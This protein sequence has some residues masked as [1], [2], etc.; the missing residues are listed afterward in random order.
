MDTSVLDP[1]GL[2]NVLVVHYPNLAHYATPILFYFGI[3]WWTC[4]LI[5]TYISPPP[6]GSKL[7]PVWNFMKFFMLHV[8]YASTAVIPGMQP[9]VIVASIEIST[10]S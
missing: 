7:I 4:K 6:A 2:L 1:I 9:A 3:F 8:K 5:T 10:D